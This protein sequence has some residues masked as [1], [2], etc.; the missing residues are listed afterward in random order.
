MQ[1]LIDQVKENVRVMAELLTSITQET[2]VGLLTYRDLS[3]AKSSYVTRHLLLTDQVES[4]ETWMKHIRAGGGGDSPE[5]VLQGLRKTLDAHPWRKHA[6]RVVTIIGDAP[7]H[8]QD[9][10]ALRQLC[11]KA[12]RD[13]FVINTV[14]LTHAGAARSGRRAP[15]TTEGMSDREL[16]GVATSITFADIARWGGGQAVVQD[17][18]ARVIADLLRT[19]FGA[20][21]KDE[22]EQF[23]E[24]YLL[25]AISESS[26]RAA[27]RKTHGKPNRF[28]RRLLGEP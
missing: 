17:D 25:F 19:A 6:T 23:V 22:V 20:E 12:A 8:A 1:P 9:R 13:G 2:R 27:H 26:L 24:A 10:P 3:D 11:E 21:W 28:R 14:A 18:I 16:L 7:P 4:L 15:A 5:A